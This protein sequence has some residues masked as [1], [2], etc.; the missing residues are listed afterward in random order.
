MLWQFDSQ[1]IKHDYEAALIE[2]DTKKRKKLI[3]RIY[4]KTINEL[5][6]IYIL[7]DDGK[8]NYRISSLK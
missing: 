1:R 6:L 8:G 2:T 7:V 4:K 5:K 3:K